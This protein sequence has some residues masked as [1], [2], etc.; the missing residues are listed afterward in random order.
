MHWL[1]GRTHRAQHLYWLF[2]MILREQ[3]P[4]APLTTLGVGGPGRYFVEA[5]AED[6]VREALGFAREFDLPVFVMGGGSNLVVADAGFNGVVVKIAL[7]GVEKA[8]SGADTSFA[9]AAGEDWDGLVAR[10]VE[11]D[12]AG[13]ECLSGIPGT[14]GGT[15]VQNVGA[16][17]QEVAE[18]LTEVEALDRETLE[19]ARFSNG[20]C[21]FGY[22]TSRFN[23]H[24][25]GRYIILRVR[26]GL[27]RGGGPT[28]RYADVQKAVENGPAKPSLQQVRDAVLAIRRSKSMVLVP[29]DENRRSCGSFFKNPVI[30]QR[31]FEELAVR[32]ESCRLSMPNYQVGDGWRKLSAAWLVEHAG[33]VKGYTRASVG[34]S[35]RHALAIV[36]RGG[37][38]AAEVVALKNEIQAR[39]RNEFGIELD[40]EP[41]FVGF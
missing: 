5:V 16:Y 9:V 29:D 30:S 6:D 36:N 1:G 32:M 14:V 25:R 12:C 7:K 24:D 15:P 37:A 40:P 10:A 20:E 3:V 27:R 22:R 26:F 39:V 28:L 23:T 21:G 18:T 13:I 38:T 19:V 34:I 17:G 8:E 4:L 41:V 2:N 33:F 11:E 35:T 31:E